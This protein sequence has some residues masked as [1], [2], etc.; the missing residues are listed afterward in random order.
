[1][2]LNR[3]SLSW[4][5]PLL[6]LLLVGLLSTWIWHAD[7]AR[8]QK[9]AQADFEAGANDIVQILETHMT[10]Y[11]QLLLGGR[12][13]FDASKT[14]SRDEWRLYVA[15]LDLAENYPG[16]LGIAW[17]P[18]LEADDR[19]TFID[20]A[21]QDGFADFTI[22]PVAENPGH[23]GQAVTLY[24][25]PLTAETR[26][27][28]G[29]DMYTEE[30]RRTAM[31]RARDSGKPALSERVYLVV[32][33]PASAREAVLMYVPVYAGGRHPVT[34]AE[35]RQT[36]KGFVN[37][38]IRINDLM[39]T[40]FN[41]VGDIRIRIYDGERA[42]PG[43]LLYAN[44][45]E[46]P[47]QAAFA[48]TK[49]L[50]IDGRTWTL[51]LSS[52]PVYALTPRV[53]HVDLL[54]GAGWLL[55]VL[56][57]TLVAVL[58][59]MRLRAERLA[60][61]MS[62]K[63]RRSSHDMR[64]IMDHM[65]AIICYID[66]DGTI[67]YANQRYSEWTGGRGGQAGGQLPG[68]GVMS[69]S[70]G[71]LHRKVL[72]AAMAGESQRYEGVAAEGRIVDV[73]IIPDVGSNGVEGVFVFA[74]DISERKR[75]EASLHEEKE[76]A[77]VTLR[78]I[79]DAVL[80][81]DVEGQVTYLNPIAEAMTEWPIG[82]ALGRHVDEILSLVAG[83]TERKLNPLAR[84][85]GEDRELGGSLDTMLIRP[86]GRRLAL[87][88]SAAPIHD[89]QKRVVGGVIVFRDVSE[90]RAMAL[91]MTHLARH[92]HL[93]DLPNRIL[94]QDRLVQAMSRA[95]HS[96]NSIGLLF[97]D[98]DR[99]K[100]INDS[101]GHP[102]GDQ[103]LQ[104]VAR[105][106][107]TAVNADDTVSRQGGDEFVVV[108][109]GIANAAD[110]T[111]EAQKILQALAAPF[112]VD[113]H[114]LHIGASIGIS[115]YPEDGDDVRDLMKQAD[116]AMYHAKNSGRG[117]YRLFTRDMSQQAHRRLSLERELRHAVSNGALALHYQPKV[118]AASG[119]MTGVEALVRWQLSNGMSIS[120]AEFIPLAEETGL[121]RDIDAWVLR[122][123]C[124]QG[125]IWADMGWDQLT[126][127][128][129]L[130]LARFDPGIMHDSLT[131]ALGESGFDPRHLEVELLESEMLRNSRVTHDWIE[132]LKSIGIRVA[133]DDFG[134]GYSGLSYLQNFAL[135]TLKI[136][137]SF[138]NMLEKS[139]GTRHLVR[140]IVAMALALDYRVVAE[141]VETEEQ[142]R[143]LREEGCH[144]LQGFL[145]HRPMPADQLTALLAHRA[146]HKL[147]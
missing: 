98:L 115:L 69:S 42:D 28:I 147:Q 146:A 18:W 15:G 127:A 64:I 49:Q 87:E 13:L 48:S 67:R 78:S 62:E 95:Q 113:D 117:C 23:A 136:D 45:S 84:A 41:H 111:R 112:Q 106:L 74:S 10:T 70:V 53:A 35:R 81:V 116:T 12:G 121:I 39:P 141:G 93:T 79:G 17:S 145:F 40:I 3:R 58:L 63:A 139:G 38:A 73:S 142:A 104:L 29:Y 60:G 34:V 114:E 124:R 126:V 22:R 101:L 16:L 68:I 5:L 100:H 52:L 24:I 137:R 131:A 26:R 65:P 83:D 133:I 19:A 66:E 77:E 25:E 7:R 96:G 130:S 4:A 88:H 138:V 94:L 119:R 134:T 37:A 27:A 31:D 56:L 102:V 75:M 46:E 125:A 99:F 90:A 109:E 105:R 47:T 51:Q 122:E 55:A 129:N 11:R 140:A 82:H 9:A 44:T 72:D 30:H 86:D 6:T 76:R 97:I 143:I 91:R 128:V 71:G 108:L 32:D 1:M 50:K 61:R 132:Q 89:D 92:D 43:H 80:V 8:L 118:D 110:A 20:A 123:A 120:P 21:R 54:L 107:Q 14:I 59:H 144:D 103:L 36:L 33:D 2:P 135:D 57:A 85:M